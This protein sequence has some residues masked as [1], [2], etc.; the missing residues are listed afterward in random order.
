MVWKII[1]SNDRCTHHPD[2]HSDWKN[3]CYITKD[4]KCNYENCPF[5]DKDYD[6]MKRLEKMYE[7]LSRGDNGNPW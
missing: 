6:K 7:I 4:G 3:R 1:I 5:V 2:Y